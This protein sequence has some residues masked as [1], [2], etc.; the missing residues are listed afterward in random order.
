MVSAY[1]DAKHMRAGPREDTRALLPKTRGNDLL[2]GRHCV[3]A[4]RTTAA[5]RA[6]LSGRFYAFLRALPDP[7]IDCDPDHAGDAVPPPPPRT[8]PRGWRPAQ[9]EHEGRRTY[10]DC[11]CHQSPG[12]LRSSPIAMTTN[13]GGLPA[14]RHER[15]R[16]NCL[17]LSVCFAAG[18]KTGNG[19]GRAAI[20][21]Q[22]R[23][24]WLS[25]L[26]VPLTPHLQTRDMR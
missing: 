3:Q 11:R 5:R 18:A 1:N 4:Q 14:A 10:C 16:V 13:V 17:H 22:H 7:D 21:R 6:A 26:K 20:G 23:G 15:G 25:R 24:E 2:L 8:A 19:S 12:E 9:R